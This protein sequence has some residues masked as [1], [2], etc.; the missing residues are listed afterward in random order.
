MKK[1]T[2]ILGLSALATGAFAQGTVSIGN[3]SY[4]F[5]R[6]NATALSGGTAGNTAP[7]LGSFY[8]AVF[9]AASTVTSVDA[10]LQNLFNPSIWTFT[11]LYAT[12]SAVAT[13]GR[14]MN[15][16]ATGAAGAPATG[17]TPG[18]TNSF[19]LLG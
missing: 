3:G 15:G 17:W 10:N 19:I 8:Y 16:G 11:G 1:L 4:A 5:A 2:A 9:T 6:T 7:I 13:G 18:Q 12:N 14:L